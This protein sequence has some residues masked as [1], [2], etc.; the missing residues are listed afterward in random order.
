[1]SVRN[2]VV[3][4]HPDDE[5]IG[6]GGVICKQKARG[7]ETAAV[8]LTSGEMGLKQHAAEVARQIREG[9]ARRS[10]E[11]LGIA[12]C[13]FLRGPDWTLADALDSV[14]GPLAAVLR[15]WQPDRIFLPHPNDAH[16]DHQAALPLVQ[17]ALAASGIAPPELLGYEVWTPLGS[18]DRVEDIS[19]FMA[20]KLQALKAH[21]S[22]LN[23]YNYPRAVE[24]LNC[25]RGALAARCAFAEVFATLEPP[26]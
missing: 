16:P 20:T 9:E 7:E 6:C 15:E 5:A 21:V 12:H 19:E 1:M 4:P 22:Q 24:G 11:V 25:Y 14:V 17:R 10:A 2:L 8:F 3:A 23:F 18:Y 26:S 13:D